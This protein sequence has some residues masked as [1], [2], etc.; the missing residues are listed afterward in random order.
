[1]NILNKG[2]C[3]R[4]I[5]SKKKS[6][7]IGIFRKKGEKVP[8]GEFTNGFDQYRPIGAKLVSWLFCLKYK[9]FCVNVAGFVCKEPPMGISAE[10][11]EKLNLIETAM[12]NAYVDVIQNGVK[13]ELQ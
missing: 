2:R 7:V 4:C 13:R 5:A 10:D 6:Q 11:Y 3:S 12:A 1:M 9:K 8:E